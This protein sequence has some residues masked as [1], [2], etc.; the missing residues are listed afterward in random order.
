MS[1]PLLQVFL[2][3]LEI[4]TCVRAYDQTRYAITDTNFAAVAVD[5]D[6]YI[7]KE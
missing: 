7:T 1:N 2:L 6:Q 5:G 3:R 4:F